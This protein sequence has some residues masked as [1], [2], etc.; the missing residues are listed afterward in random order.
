LIRRPFRLALAAVGIFLFLNFVLAVFERFAPPKAV[1]FYRKYI[2]NPALRGWS[3]FMPGF[4]VVEVVGRK[5]GKRHR[6]NVGG[7][8][9]G[10]AFWFLA[11]SDAQYVRNLTA[12]P[13]VRIRFHGRWH[14]G[15]AHALRDS[16]PRER[17]L[18]LNP[19]NGAFLWVVGA[20][21]LTIRVDLEEG[22]ETPA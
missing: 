14:Q 6:V 21:L 7:R 15:L 17:L 20:D 8:R 18:R 9:I 12:N 22:A 5:T 16:D 11:R 3:S 2:G 13:R 1:R 19:M 10:E 4:A